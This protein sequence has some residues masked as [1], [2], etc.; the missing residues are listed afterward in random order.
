MVGVMM[1]GILLSHGEI[2]LKMMEGRQNSA[3]YKSLMSDFA[4]PLIQVK[5]DNDFCF[6]QD[7][8]LI[9]IYKEMQKQFG[10]V[11]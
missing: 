3:K 4:L 11:N 9:H 10:N 5:A 6:Q 1:W 8:C 7:M 2:L